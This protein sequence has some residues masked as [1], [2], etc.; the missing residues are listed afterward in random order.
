MVAGVGFSNTDIVS[1]VQQLKGSEYFVNV[2]LQGTTR[3]MEHATETYNFN[4][5]LEIKA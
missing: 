5:I 1:F 4:L 3:K 2:E